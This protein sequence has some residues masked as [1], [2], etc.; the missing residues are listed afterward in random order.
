MYRPVFFLGFSL[1]RGR[2]GGKILSP[3]Y[4]GTV[5][6]VVFKGFGDPP[7]TTNLLRTIFT[8]KNTKKRFRLQNSRIF[9]TKRKRF[10]LQNPKSKISLKMSEFSHTH[11]K[12]PAAS[13]PDF[14]KNNT[15][16]NV[17]SRRFF[18]KKY[19]FFVL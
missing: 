5:P 4:L 9:T 8:K 6:P 16:K 18:T 3:Q 2:F 19:L 17:A 10:G 15:Q 12:T 1:G 7:K 13:R 11:T 14:H